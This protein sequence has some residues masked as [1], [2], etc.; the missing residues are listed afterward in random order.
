MSSLPMAWWTPLLHGKSVVV[1][2]W[3]SWCENQSTLDY[4]ENLFAGIE[5]KEEAVV[6]Q[7]L[8]SGQD[9]DCVFQDNALVHAVAENNCNAMAMLLNGGAVVGFIPPGRMQATVHIA[10]IGPPSILE[11]VLLSQADSNVP[12]SV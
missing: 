3:C 4:T 5:A 11:Q 8:H 6:Y 7:C 2:T 10:A 1:L 12:D 9:P